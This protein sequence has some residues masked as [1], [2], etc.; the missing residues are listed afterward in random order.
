MLSFPGRSGMAAVL[1]L[2][3][4]VLTLAAVA[5]HL[6]DQSGKALS[7]FPKPGTRVVVLV[8]GATDCPISNRYVPEVERLRGE[9][10]ARAVDLR[11]V[12]PNPDDTPETVRKHSVEYGMKVPVVVD[13]E[14]EL[15]QKAGVRVTPEAAVFAVEPGGWREVYHGRIDDRYIAF[16]KERPQATR[17]EL[18]EA[19]ESALAG[20]TA[21]AAGGDPVGCSIV[22]KG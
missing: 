20:K 14:Q 4:P 15:V 5:A 12:Y 9:F 10:A 18:E 21:A 11:W 1:L 13:R 2:C 6:L 22:P 3:L 16:G 17:H 8:F 7:G 19:I